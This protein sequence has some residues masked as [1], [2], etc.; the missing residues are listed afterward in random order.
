MRPNKLD[1]PSCTDCEYKGNSFFCDLSNNELDSIS[2]EK[3]HILFKKGQII[4]YEGNHPLGIYCIYSGKAKI[5]KLGEG[6]KE[7]IV[8]FSKKSDILGYR[9]VLSGEPYSASATALEDTKVCLITKQSFQALLQENIN[10]SMKSIQI[11][12]NDLKKA[13]EKLLNMAQKPVRERVAEALLVLRDCF[14]YQEDGVTINTKILR[15]EVGSLAGTSTETAIRMI[16]EFN[17]DGFIEIKGKE[18]A[19]VNLAKLIKTANVYD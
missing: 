2:L 6:G 10:F 9:A 5:H 17:K 4:F 16:S 7:Q 12:S 19:I 8:R 13:E 14:G 15:R 18:I 1:I 11:L 3:S